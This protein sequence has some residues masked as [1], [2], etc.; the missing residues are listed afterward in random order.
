M[1]GRDSQGNWVAKERSGI[2]G[3]LFVDRATALKFAKAESGRDPHAIVWV[4]GEVELDLAAASTA[5]SEQGLVATVTRKR[6]AA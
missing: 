6:R 4:S 3:G 2:R 5:A 1:I